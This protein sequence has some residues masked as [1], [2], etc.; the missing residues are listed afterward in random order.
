[1]VEQLTENDSQAGE[2]KNN[3][4]QSEYSEEEPEAETTMIDNSARGSRKVDKTRTIN[5]EPGTSRGRMGK[6][7]KLTTVGKSIVV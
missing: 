4:E 7:R 1:M 3:T 6:V 2:K 5:E